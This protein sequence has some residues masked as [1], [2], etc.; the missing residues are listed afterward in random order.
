MC[1]EKV[2]NHIR[3]IDI[4]DT[5]RAFSPAKSWFIRKGPKQ[6]AKK[7]VLHRDSSFNPAELIQAFQVRWNPTG[8]TEDAALHQGAQ[9][10]LTQNLYEA[11]PELDIV[12]TLAFII[13]TSMSSHLRN[14]VMTTKQ[15]NMIWKLTLVDQQSD[16]HIATLATSVDIIPQEKVGRLFRRTCSGEDLVQLIHPTT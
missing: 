3:T 9:W 11:F 13:E 5:F 15:M 8:N 14:L 12:Q 16:Q 4:G 1:F 2:F 10:E 7:V 6:I